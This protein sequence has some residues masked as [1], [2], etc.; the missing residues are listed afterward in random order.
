MTRKK[1]L[2][3]MREILLQRREALMQALAGDDSLLQQ[4][5]NEQGGD[6]VDFASGSACGELSSQLAE[7]CGRE[8]E[9]IANALSHM[10]QGTYGK[11][12]ACGC[13]IPL[14]RLEVLPYA[15][16]CVNCKRKIEESG[17][18]PGASVDWSTILGVPG[19]NSPSD[20]DLNFS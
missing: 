6:I 19:T 8:L 20:L 18:E 17:I 5:N 9:A 10:Q 1:T 2:E 3:S 13:N 7:F 11:C 12:E 15:S 14:A 4:L 16:F